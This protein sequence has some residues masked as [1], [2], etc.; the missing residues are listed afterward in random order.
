M[1]SPFIF[2]ALFAKAVCVTVCHDMPCKE[3]GMSEGMPGLGWGI[4]NCFYSLDLEK[5]PCSCKG[6]LARMGWFH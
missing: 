6:S 4:L 2:L 1:A 5:N 3:K